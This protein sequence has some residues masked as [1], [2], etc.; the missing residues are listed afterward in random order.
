MSD[1]VDGLFRGHNDHGKWRKLRRIE[2]GG[3]TYSDSDYMTTASVDGEVLP[4]DIVTLKRNPSGRAGGLQLMLVLRAGNGAKVARGSCTYSATVLWIV[5]ETNADD[6]ETVHVGD[7]TPL[8]TI[9]ANRAVIDSEVGAGEIA[10]R[11]HSLASFP[12]AA[13]YADL[14]VREIG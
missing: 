10:V 5:R 4:E 9:P 12:A 6:T 2:P 14:W 8:T 1:S 3:S 7:S 13:K 11:I